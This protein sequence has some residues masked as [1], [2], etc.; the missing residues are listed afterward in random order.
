MWIYL[1]RCICS[2][3]ASAIGYHTIHKDEPSSYPE[4]TKR[5]AFSN[6][7]ERNFSSN[8]WSGLYLFPDLS[9]RVS[10]QRYLNG[11][12]FYLKT[13]PDS[14]PSYRV[15]EVVTY[16][17]ADQ[18]EIGKITTLFL[19]CVYMGAVAIYRGLCQKKYIQF[20]LL[21]PFPSIGSMVIKNR[22]EKLHSKSRF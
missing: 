7:F 10:F 18:R 19:S 17:I 1:N 3:A 20:V 13:P 6:F 16:K 12:F 14:S 9:N 22:I 4:P 11:R 15:P 2:G 5:V 21:F 8:A